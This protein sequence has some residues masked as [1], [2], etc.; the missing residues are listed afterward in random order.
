[1]ASEIVL[2][3]GHAYNV[4]E[5]SDVVYDLIRAFEARSAWVELHLHSTDGNQWHGRPIRLRGAAI[6][7]V[8]HFEDD[9]ERDL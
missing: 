9:D 8:S 4:T 6:I 2:S 1:M 5:S 3:N 7:C